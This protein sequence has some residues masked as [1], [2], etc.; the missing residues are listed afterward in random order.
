[1]R[2]NYVLLTLT[3]FHLLLKI[4]LYCHTESLLILLIML[5][6]VLVNYKCAFPYSCP[7]LTMTLL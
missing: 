3:N 6:Y 7:D 4:I 5:V 2:L 1:M